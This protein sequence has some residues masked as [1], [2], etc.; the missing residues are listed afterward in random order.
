MFGTWPVIDGVM[1][2]VKIIVKEG[3]IKV[4]LISGL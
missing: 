4:Y 3:L 2:I 1:E